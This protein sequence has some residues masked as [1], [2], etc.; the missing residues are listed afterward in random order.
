MESVIDQVGCA[1]ETT[2]K[3]GTHPKILQ[4]RGIKLKLRGRG[5][6]SVVRLESNRLPPLVSTRL[7]VDVGLESAAPNHERHPPDRSGLDGRSR[8]ADLRSRG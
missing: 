1:E 5:R 4:S 8:C 2:Q 7:L 6:G 3:V